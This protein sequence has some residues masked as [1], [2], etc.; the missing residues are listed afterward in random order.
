MVNEWSS[1]CVQQCGEIA[2][3][4]SWRREESGEVAERVGRHDYT[5]EQSH[6]W[7]TSHISACHCQFVS[8]VLL[9]MY[10]AGC[11]RLT[12]LFDFPPNSFDIRMR[13]WGKILFRPVLA[14]LYTAVVYG[15]IQFMSNAYSPVW[16][17]CGKKGWLNKSWKSNEVVCIG[18]ELLCFLLVRQSQFVF[19]G[20]W[21][22]PSFVSVVI[23]AS[24]ADCL[25]RFVLN[26]AFV[27]CVTERC[28]GTQQFLMLASLHGTQSSSFVIQWTWH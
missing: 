26:D 21:L 24:A 10:M 17:N 28:S 20:I 11:S 19:L 1:R 6:E 22:F 15:Y 23:N 13:I 7:G 25:V 9:Q 4:D 16:N 14:V 2:R 5:G 12:F 27:E 8:T 18:L 3:E